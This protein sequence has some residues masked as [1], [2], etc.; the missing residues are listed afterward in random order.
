MSFIS[1]S[2]VKLSSVDE[3]NSQ[4]ATLVPYPMTGWYRESSTNFCWAICAVAVTGGG[5]TL[6]FCGNSGETAVE[7]MPNDTITDN[8]VN[9]V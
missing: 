6:R 7:W 2:M 4:L 3:L 8:V 9:I 1:K 5:V